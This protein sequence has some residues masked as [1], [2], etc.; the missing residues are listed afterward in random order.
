[1][2]DTAQESI[3][4]FIMKAITM[5]FSDSRFID[6]ADC[7]KENG[8]LTLLSLHSVSAVIYFLLKRHYCYCKKCGRIAAF[9]SIE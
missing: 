2:L 9:I 5:T 1:M 7:N 3:F 6:E 4:N 8:V